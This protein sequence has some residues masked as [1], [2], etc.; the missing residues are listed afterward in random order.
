MHFLFNLATNSKLAYAA[1]SQ[2]I[3]KREGID[4]SPGLPTI[5]SKQAQYLYVDASFKQT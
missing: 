3:I 1:R 5:R 4:F 2:K